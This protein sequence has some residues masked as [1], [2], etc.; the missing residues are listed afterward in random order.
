MPDKRISVLFVCLGNICRSPTAEGVFEALLAE[1]D[2]AGGDTLLR[3]RV[4]VD[5]AGVSDWHRGD[6]PDP[7]SQEEALCHGIDLSGQRSRPVSEND[8]RDF[9]YVISMDNEVLEVLRQACQKRYREKLHLFTEFAPGVGAP[10]VP[11]PYEGGKNGFA[12]VYR[13]VEACSRGLLK[14]IEESGDLKR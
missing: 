8:F 7:R 10:E 4:S 13:L 2:S 9:D 1:R 6:P 11:D 5:S 3:D 12:Y 14:H